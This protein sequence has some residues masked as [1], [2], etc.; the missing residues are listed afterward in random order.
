MKYAAYN[1]NDTVLGVFD[2]LEE[3]QAEADVYRTATGNASYADVSECSMKHFLCIEEGEF[4]ISKASCIA[5]A[6]QN[7]SMYG[8]SAVREL[9]AKELAKSNLEKGE[10]CIDNTL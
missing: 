8:G 1:H 10:Y 7:A 5:N 6:Q 9:T 2:T 3:A 4:F